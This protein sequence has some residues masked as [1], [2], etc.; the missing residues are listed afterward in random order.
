MPKS[1]GAVAAKRPWRVWIIAVAVFALTAAIFS[2]AIHAGFVNYDDEVYV[3]ANPA[4]NH[5][6]TLS[7]IT[8]AF[9][10]PHARNWHPITTITH[11]LD[12]ELFGVNPGGHHAINVLLHSL[13]AA[14]LFLVLHSMTGSTWRAGVVAVVFALHPLRVESVAWIAER[15]DVL[16]ALFFMG[17]LGAYIRYTRAPGWRT[18]WP[19]IALFAG[20]LMAKPMLISVPFVLLLLDFWP[21]RRL[22]TFPTTQPG[23]PAISFSRAVVEKIPLFVLSVASAIATLLA[24]HGS[25]GALD[26][27]PLIDR[28]GNAALSYCTYI[29]Q[30]IW[31]KRLAVFYPLPLEQSPLLTILGAAALL[32]GITILAVA[33]RRHS[34]YFCTGWFWYLIMLGPVIGILQIGLQA[35]ADRYT[36]LPQ[37]GLIIAATWA[38]VALLRRSRAMWM[39]W[40]AAVTIVVLLGWRTL[41]QLTF[42]RDSETLWNYTLAVTKDN[43]VALANLGAVYASRGELNRALE[44]YRTGLEVLERRASLRYLLSRALVHN[45]IG[46]VFLR[47]GEVSDAMQEYRQSIA[48]RPDFGNAYVNLGQAYAQTGDWN[49]ALAEYQNAI[50]L[51]PGDADAQ[52]RAGVA[53]MR[54]GRLDDAISHYRSALAAEPE[55]AAAEVD[56]GNSVLVQ[57]NVEDA[58]NHYRRAVQINPQ[59]PD[60]H[61]NLG[62]ILLQQRHFTDAIAEYQRVVALQPGDAGAH[63]A[64][65]NALAAAAS[66]R[67]AVDEIEKA[68][69]LAP[70][71]ISAL[72]NLAWLLVSSSDPAVRDP[73]RAVTLAE[74][75]A[76]LARQPDA[77]IY[78]TLAAAYAGAGKTGEAITA[79]ER[80]S[81]L[82]AANGDKA[83][84]AAVQHDL[85]IY[86]RL[87]PP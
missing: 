27:V 84:A 79:A 78:H 66:E 29:Y 75:A 51:Q 3:Y 9:T 40:P 41:E 4:I 1:K 7:G 36:Y 46:N 47:R 58:A 8:R 76:Q 56:L 17:V 86:R 16:S 39:A 23:L 14:A 60:A 52:H 69:D 59:T 38:I 42:W 11:M 22:R 30:F 70:D 85:E 15:K 67:Q 65:G 31:P 71:S 54:L 83:L 43:D 32:V 10:Q 20:G 33:L 18:M 45:N 62:R 53:L 6:F 5:G 13:A 35:H 28:L 37:I 57:G 72:N 34:P 44:Q 2:P 24:A 74:K 73:T 81:E 63:L 68:L 19:V 82:A 49:G 50:R 25:E 80:C 64:L 21:L 26:T 55:F 77:L 87:S 61:F 48:L 12:C